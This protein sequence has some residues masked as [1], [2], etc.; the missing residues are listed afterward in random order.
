MIVRVIPHPMLWQNP[1]CNYKTN[2]ATKGNIVLMSK[3]H[4]KTPRWLGAESPTLVASSRLWRYVKEESSFG[5]PLVHSHH[6]QACLGWHICRV[7]PRKSCTLDS[8]KQRSDL[9]LLTCGCVQHHVRF[10]IARRSHGLQ[11][12]FTAPSKT[13]RA[14]K[15]AGPGSCTAAGIRRRE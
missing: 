7:Q 3:P 1:S 2:P 15:D 9:D 5:N 10:K 6:K 4:I 13:T 14:S 8:G 12:L 11:A